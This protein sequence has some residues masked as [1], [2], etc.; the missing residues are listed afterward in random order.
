MPAPANLS[1]KPTRASY[2]RM[3]AH[4]TIGLGI[5]TGAALVAGP[6]NG[7]SCDRCAGL[8][9]STCGC[10]SEIRP[11]PKHC[12]CKCVP[13]QSLGEQLLS[14]FDKV[15]DRFEAKAKTS[16]NGLCDHAARSRHNLGPTCGCQSSQGP[17]CG[18]DFNSDHPSHASAPF[19]YSPSQN[20]TAC[21]FTSDPNRFAIGSIGDKHINTPVNNDPLAK[22]T[23]APAPDPTRRPI[24]VERVPGEQKK[25]THE[26][27]NLSDPPPAW[28]PASKPPQ[29][30]NPIAPTESKLPDVL[31]D[32][33]KDD[34]SFRGTRQKME[35]ILLTSDRQ[36]SNRYLRL[37]PSDRVA[38]EE[39]TPIR[40]KKPSRLSP[41]KQSG[42]NLKF[43][44]TESVTSNGSQV[45]PSNFSE[46]SIEKA[47]VRKEIPKRYSDEMP[48]VPRTRVPTKR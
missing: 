34:V 2:A 21:P 22:T 45:V 18:C 14:H 41:I 5:S 6:A 42:P 47:F 13:K 15:G 39:S 17:K 35:G 48:L 9:S 30:T 27:T 36:L 8:K 43:E 46:E 23:I 4:I 31:V 26:F 24:L 37:A 10:E 44:A 29:E 33:F 11:G 1:K 28:A 32:P 20:A 3:L 7:Q 40:S 19:Q 25:S 38:E 12:N 16:C